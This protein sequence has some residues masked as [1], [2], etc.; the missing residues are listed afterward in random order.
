MTRIRFSGSPLQQRGLSVPV[1]GHPGEQRLNPKARRRGCKGGRAAPWRLGGG[2]GR[3]DRLLLL[4][5]LLLLQLHLG[6]QV[7]LLKLAYLRLIGLDLRL[8]AEIAG[9]RGQR[10]LLLL[11]LDRLLLLNLQL[12]LLQGL[13]RGGLPGDIG[14]AARGRRE[15]HGKNEDQ[16][17][18]AHDPW[19]VGEGRL[20]FQL[21]W[22]IFR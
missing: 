19:K 8:M 5:A 1:A 12:L 20:W 6:G 10:P 14:L 4:L 11:K 13:R 22:S 2:R 17:D 3:R 7:I 16:K 21:G 9:L 18:S 15:S